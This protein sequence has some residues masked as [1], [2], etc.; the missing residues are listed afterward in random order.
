VRKVP[1]YPALGKN[2]RAFAKATRSQKKRKEKFRWGSSRGTKV[3]SPSQANRNNGDEGQ[4]S[5]KEEKKVLGRKGSAQRKTGTQC[6]RKKSRNKM[7]G[8][9]VEKGDK[10]KRARRK[11]GTS[12]KGVFFERPVRGRPKKNASEGEH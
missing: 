5:H 7:P 1:V 12:E 3:E 8:F 4:A 2:W 11:V 6:R 10:K 9:W